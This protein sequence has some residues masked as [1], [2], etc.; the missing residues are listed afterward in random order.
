MP[1]ENVRSGPKPKKLRPKRRLK[2]AIAACRDAG[3]LVREARIGAD[4]EVRIIIGSRSDPGPPEGEWG[5]V[6]PKDMPG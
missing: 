6:G 3:L 2:E 5:K 1:I 4:G